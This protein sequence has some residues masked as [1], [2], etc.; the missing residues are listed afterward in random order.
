MSPQP[1]SAGALF[2]RF[3]DTYDATRR[4]LIPPFDAFYGTA[5]EVA[6]LRLT[7]DEPV[8]VLDIGAGTGLLTARLATVVPKAT[9]TL[10]DASPAMLEHA[11][12]RLGADWARCRTVV[13]DAIEALPEGPFDAIVTALA[14]HH[15]DDARKRELY[16]RVLDCLRPGGVFVNAEQVAGPTPELDSL[17]VER[18]LAQTRA[19]G[20]T[21][22]DHEQAAVRM[23]MDLP[24]SVESQC[25][26]LRAVGFVD[27]DCFFKQWRFAV[28]GGWKAADSS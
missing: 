9:F 7:P 23:S 8:A 3:A 21:D 25:D 18:W 4:M 28:F 5:V 15:L 12:D 26:W 19:L 22:H 17:Y 14:V 11:P 24:A 16:D 1:A 27:V 13:G 2:E 20:A 6:T 10:L